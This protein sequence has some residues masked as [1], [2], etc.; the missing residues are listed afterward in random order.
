MVLKL[1]KSSRPNLPMYC[2]LTIV[3]HSQRSDDHVA[4]IVKLQHAQDQLDCGHVASIV[5]VQHAQDQLD[6][7]DG[8]PITLQSTSRGYHVPSVCT[9]ISNV[10]K[11]RLA[12]YYSIYFSEEM[13]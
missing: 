3:F 12:F 6:Y 13:R 11:G 4:S 1:R 7:D 8:Q 10:Q 5:K 2:E 9:G